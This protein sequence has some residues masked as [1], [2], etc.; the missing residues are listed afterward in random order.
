[1]A[2][3]VL[4][5]DPKNLILFAGFQA[6][7]TR[8]EAL[9]HGVDHIKIHGEMVPVR[10][11]VASLDSLSAHADADEILDWLRKTGRPPKMTFI[12]HGEA[13]AAEALRKRIQEELEWPC[14][15]P[16]YLEHVAL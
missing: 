7:G 13:L 4:A 6:A 10:A 9:I 16:D 2:L 8:G 11:Q 5:P 1:V 3:K 14:R 15:V 12:T